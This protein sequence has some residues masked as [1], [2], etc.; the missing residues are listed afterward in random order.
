M[1]TKQHSDINS[2]LQYLA[3][4][5]NSIVEFGGRNLK[6]SELYKVSGWPLNRATSSHHYDVHYNNNN[7]YDIRMAG[8]RVVSNINPVAVKTPPRIANKIEHQTSG[9]KT[10]I[11]YQLKSSLSSQ[12][13]YNPKLILSQMLAIQCFHYVFF[14]L[15]IQVNNVIFATSMTLDRIFTTKYLN[16]WSA[17]GWIDN[18]AVLLTFIFQAVL[19][20]VIVEKSR[21]CL[22]FSCTLFFI[23]FCVCSIYGGFPATWDWWIIHL[24]GTI[25]MILMGEFL[26]SRKE[27]MDIPLLTL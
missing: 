6:R 10:R 25:I 19:L 18:Y 21:K 4:S 20:A 5:R 23:H 1:H 13:A 8:R 7:Y 12:V 16:F 26:C 15:V 14:G 9:S 3:S 24:S 27:L 11:A 22:D 2:K 17:E